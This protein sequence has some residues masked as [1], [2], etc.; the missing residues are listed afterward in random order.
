GDPQALD[1]LRTL[2][3]DRAAPAA[4][5]RGALEA[6]APMHGPVM[7]EL[8]D[9][10]LGDPDL[11]AAA[12]RGLAS[13]DDAQIPPRLLGLYAKLTAAE[14]QDAVGTLASRPAFALALFAAIESG[15]VDRRDVSAF[16]VRQLASLG[17]AEVARRLKAAW[18]EVRPTG[19]EKAAI[20]RRL[21]EKLTDDAL[22]AADPSQGRAVFSQTCASCHE[23]FGEGRKIG[24]D[25]TGSQRTN[26]DYILENAVDP[27]AVVGR[28]HRMTTVV[29]LAGRV[30]NGLVTQ[31]TAK[32]LTLETATETVVVAK[33]DVDE[34]QESN[35][36]MMPEGILEKLTDEELRNLIAYL[37][38]PRQVPLPDDVSASSENPT[39]ETR[40]HGERQ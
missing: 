11:R 19:A 13:Y 39:A 6:L 7:L 3:A 36:S 14:R 9:S 21:K 18:G 16:T 25:L 28:D 24:P 10:L 23:L 2:A 27:S 15:Q 34:R 4:E 12:I 35:L 20:I 29:T 37:A 1:D 31:E 30:I 32:T 38:S 17:D 26:L 40:R 8:L 22:A 33:D 5:R